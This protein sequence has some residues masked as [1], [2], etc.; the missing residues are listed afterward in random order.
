MTYCK[1]GNNWEMVSPESL[2]DTKTITP[3]AHTQDLTE[4]T[5]VLYWNGKPN[6]DVLLNRIGEL[7]KEKEGKIRIIKAWEEI[8]DSIHTDPTHDASRSIAEKLAGL[9]P[10]I[11]IG[12]PGDCSGSMTWLIVDQLNIE[13][14][15]I[16]TVTLVTSPF[17][18]MAKTIPLTEGFSECCLV[19]IPHP[20]GMIPSSVIEK[21]AE[22]VINDIIKAL[23]EWRPAESNVLNRKTFPSPLLEFSGDF[24]A[25]NDYFIENKRS[26]GLPI[27]PPAKYLVKN[28]LTGTSRKPDEIIGHIPPRMGIL[29]IELLAVYA[30]MA[31]CRPEYMPVLI[32]A[33]EALLTPAAN[34]RLA[35]TGT[36]TSQLVV[37]LNGP[38]VDEIGV[39]SGQGAAGKGYRANGTI[40]YAINLI[41]YSVG[42]SMPPAIDRSTLGSPADYVCWVFGENEKAM[43]ASWKTLAE[44]MGFNAGDS[45]VTVM[46]AYP[47][48]ENMD[49]WS[50]TF[51]EHIRWWGS[52]VNPLHNMGGPAVPHGLKQNPIIVLGPEHANL[53]ASGNRGKDSFRK[54]FWEAT[55]IPLK[56]WPSGCK[57]E[58][59][60][61]LLGPVTEETLIP[62]TLKHDQFF[63]VIAGG[64]GKQ[65]HYFA[66]MP[67]AFPVSK[68]VNRSE[69]DG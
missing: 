17:I 39:A 41:A 69:K 20:I 65:S 35:L 56:I 47:P 19:E 10:D 21:K 54:A 34:L 63:I 2:V 55:R 22:D 25:V 23:T 18:E 60:Y 15:G 9:K 68:V 3:N 13:R 48:V 12:G 29:T 16:P 61:E 59:L 38:I 1:N 14:R 24:Q 7:L 43:P 11:I 51:E 31:G 28:M 5:V 58:G 57:R 33:F 44:E 49:H 45:V 53:I 6:G 4:K 37:I 62:V 36:G 42:G 52:I 8:P 27:I 46:A 32:S 30:V 40:G 67:G 26:T 50:A 66:P 64:D